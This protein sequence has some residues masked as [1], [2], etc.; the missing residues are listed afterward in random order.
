[1]SIKTKLFIYIIV[2][3]S[4]NSYAQTIKLQE[5]EDMQDINTDSLEKHLQPQQ[6]PKYLKQLLILE[7]CFWLNEKPEF[8]SKLEEIDLLA[9][10]LKRQ[11]VLP[12]YNFCQGMLSI[13]KRQHKEAFVFL[14]NAAQGF[15][16]QKDT[17]GIIRTYVN[18]AQLNLSQ[19]REEER[20][21]KAGI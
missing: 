13:K 6:P 7:Y 19:T 21:V 15:E 3:L 10:T 9:N 4:F 17:L 18:L 2:L 8:G 12:I 14:S 16:N 5:L 20:N 11:D 1:M